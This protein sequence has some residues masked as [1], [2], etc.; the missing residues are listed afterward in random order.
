MNVL[1]H[2]HLKQDTCIMQNF[3]ICTTDQILLGRSNQGEL[4]E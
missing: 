3:M 4:D 1:F 2:F